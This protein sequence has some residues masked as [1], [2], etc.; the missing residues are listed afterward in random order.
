MSYQSD[1][2]Q[3]NGRESETATLLG[4]LQEVK[5]MHRLS[6]VLIG[7][8]LIGLLAVPGMTKT[9]TQAEEVSQVMQ[10]SRRTRY[11]ED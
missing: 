1:T 4:K 5:K 6:Q 11:G 8:G 7:T 9:P 2:E 10:S 3:F